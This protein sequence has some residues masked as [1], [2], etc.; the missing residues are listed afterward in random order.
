[1]YEAI[2]EELKNRFFE[3]SVIKKHLKEYEDKV[4]KGEISSFAAAAELI[5]L[6]N[7]L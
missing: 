3:N 6:N 2:Q 7:N 4:L 1:M 5:K